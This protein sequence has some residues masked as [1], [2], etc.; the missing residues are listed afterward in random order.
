MSPLVR[1]AFISGL[2]SPQA[3]VVRSTG[4]QSA[5]AHVEVVT[6]TDGALLVEWELEGEPL[7]VD[8]ATGSTADHLDHEHEITVAAGQT[9]VRLGARS[10]ARRRFVSV[11]PH[12]GGPAVV[13]ADRRVPFEGITNFR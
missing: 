1:P 2:E 4:V 5:V 13:A 3:G 12:L 11:S 10:G 8:V 9:A 7:D 6:Q